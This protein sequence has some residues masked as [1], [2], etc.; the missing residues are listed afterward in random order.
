MFFSWGSEG[1]NG[2]PLLE[3]V[4]SAKIVKNKTFDIVVNNLFQIM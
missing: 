4:E 1:R 2:H 3:A